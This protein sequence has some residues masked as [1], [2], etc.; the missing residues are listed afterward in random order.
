MPTGFPPPT[1]HYPTTSYGR[2]QQAVPH[3]PQQPHG[4]MPQGGPAMQPPLGMPTSTRRKTNG[5]MPPQ[6]PLGMQRQQDSQS[7]W[8]AASQSSMAYYGLQHSQQ[9]IAHAIG[10]APGRPGNPGKV[11]KHYGMDNGK[12]PF[13]HMSPGDPTQQEAL[14]L[15]Q[16]IR[17][18]L[19]Q[20]HPMTLQLTSTD[21]HM[22]PFQHAVN[23]LGIDQNNNVLLADPARPGVPI[24]AHVSQLLTGWQPYDG[25]GA[26]MNP[27]VHMSNLYPTKTPPGS[28]SFAT[29]L[30]LRPDKY[31]G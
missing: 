6:L 31:W 17:H 28:P 29:G 5:S 18:E 3:A 2:S 25:S 8:N 4:P 15:A 19:G 26:S 12:I 13:E 11:Y 24:Q 23:V 16:T 7:C 21:Q 9:E 30:P 22:Q 20:Q 10:V 14:R 27:E 1:F